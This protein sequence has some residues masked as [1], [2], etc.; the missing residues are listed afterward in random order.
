MAEEV[1]SEIVIKSLYEVSNFM[2]AL[3]SGRF[4]RLSASKNREYLKK[5]SQERYHLIKSKGH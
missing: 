3:Y 2:G 1:K 5:L 4:F